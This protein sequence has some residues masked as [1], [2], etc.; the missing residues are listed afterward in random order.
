M[1][2]YAS[3]VS[4]QHSPW[5]FRPEPPMRRPPNAGPARDPAEGMRQ[6]PHRSEAQR[7]PPHPLARVPPPGRRHRCRDRSRQSQ[8]K[9]PHRGAFPDAEMHMP[10]KGQLDPRQIAALEQWID[11]GAPWD[12]KR[13]VQLNLPEKTEVTRGILPE[14]YAPILALA[15]SPD[16]KIL[17]A[18]RGDTIDWY[19]VVPANQARL[20]PSGSSPSPPPRPTTTWSNPSPFHHDGK[21]LVSGGF[22]SVRFWDPDAPQKPV[23]EITA[24]F[25]G[26]QTALLFLDGGKRLLVADSVPTP[27]GRLH[28]HPRPG[29]GQ[30]LR[31]RAPR[32]DLHTDP[33]RRR[34]TLS[35]T[36][37]D[38]L[39]VVRDTT[40]HEGREASRRPYR[41]RARG[42]LFSRRGRLASGGD[43]E[44]IKVWNLETGRR[45]DPSR[46]TERAP[47]RAHLARRSGQRKTEGRGKGQ[48]EGGGDQH[49]SHRLDP[50]VGEALGFHRVEGT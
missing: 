48:K 7:R 50:R 1:L 29:I 13:W 24:P 28:E 39:I 3:A 49:R 6:L 38:K 41:L 5:P 12:E 10:P 21:R 16:R 31:H 45:S 40:K 15:L 34:Q 11:A 25:L 35:S 46:A 47:L 43:D 19:R 18:G 36:S 27:I 30:N 22:R 4:S 8:G 42:G 14:T 17:A 44:E 20:P 23:R 32:L 37:A 33:Q 26:R 2:A 9:P